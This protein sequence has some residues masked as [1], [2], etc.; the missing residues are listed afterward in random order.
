MNRII[1]WLI[2]RSKVGANRASILMAL[3]DRPCNASQLAERLSL[4]YETIQH[5]IRILDDSRLIVS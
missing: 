3:A 2:A 4:D 1:W 5:H